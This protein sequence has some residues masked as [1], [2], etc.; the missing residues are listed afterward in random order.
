[1]HYYSGLYVV[2]IFFISLTDAASESANE[3]SINFW[4]QTNIGET[5]FY[6]QL[7]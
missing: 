1:M 2:Y 6:I 3:V 5:Y 7:K 4:L